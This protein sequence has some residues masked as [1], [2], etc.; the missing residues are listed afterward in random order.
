MIFSLNAFACI[1]L[2][3]KDRSLK[4]DI[5]WKYAPFGGVTVLEEAVV[6][7]SIQS[8]S[9]INLSWENQPYELKALVDIS[10]PKIAGEGKV[11]LAKFLEKIQRRAK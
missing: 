5:E 9:S 1:D 8:P 11:V 6:Y 4:V 2:D 7:N 3:L 10:K